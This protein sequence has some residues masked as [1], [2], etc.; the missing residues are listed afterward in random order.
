M[1]AA[2]V[3]PARHAEA[4]AADGLTR[5]NSM[6]AAGPRGSPLFCFMGNDLTRTDIE[7]GTRFELVH[8][9]SEGFA[10]TWRSPTFE[11][12]N[13]PRQI[14]AIE[15]VRNACGCGPDFHRLERKRAGCRFVQDR[16]RG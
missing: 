4:T 8:L 13:D 9:C 10:V 12:A 15:E 3:G 11:H 5:S 7:D 14:D 2:R 6:R 16:H 1:A